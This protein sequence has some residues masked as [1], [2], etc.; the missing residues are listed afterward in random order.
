VFEKFMVMGHSW[1]PESWIPFDA[2]ESE[3]R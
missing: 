1:L 2:D 3:D